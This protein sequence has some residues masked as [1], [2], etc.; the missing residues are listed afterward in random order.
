MRHARMRT[1][2]SIAAGLATS[3][4][5]AALAVGISPAQ[6]DPPPSPSTAAGYLAPYYTEGDLTGDGELT[7]DD[8]D[9]LVPAL[10]TTSAD[11]GWADVSAADYDDDSAITLTDVAD[12][13]RRLLYDDGPFD[14]VEASALDM[15]KAM[16]AGVVTSEQ[17]TQAYLDRITAYDALADETHARALNSVIATSAVALAAAQASDA[18]RAENGGPRSML[19]GI[20]ILLKDNYDTK[21]MPTTGGCGC[22]DENQTTDD[23]FMVKGLRDAGAIVLGKASLDEFAFGFVSEYSAGQPA[24]SSKLVASPYSLSRTAGG[25]SGGTGAA[26][27]AN[28]GGIGFGTDTGGSIRVPSSYNQLV[29]IR[30]TVGLASRD[31]I[32]PLALSQDTGGPMAR[33]VSDAAIALDAVTGVDSNDPRTAEQEGKVPTSYTSS[34]DPNALQG[35]KIGYLASMVGSNAT[36]TRLFQA[37]VADLQAQGAEVVPITID[38]IS[39]ILS[40]GSG[41]TNEFKHD[42]DAYIAAHLDADE[43]ERSLADIVA[44]GKY[45]PSRLNTYNTRNAVTAETYATWM[46]SHTQVL[47][48]G[49]TLVTAALDSNE[50]DAL[51]YPS[52]NPYSTQSTNLR[53]SPNTGLPAVTVPMGQAIEADATIPGAGVNLEFLGRAF[54]EADLIGMTYDYEQAT[55]H[56]TTPALYPALPGAAFRADASASVAAEASDG[57]SVTVSEPSV[58]IGDTIEVT[59]TANAAADLYA[60]DLDLGFDPEVLQYVG[61]SAGTG[62]SGATYEDAGDAEDGEVHVVHTKLGTSPAAAGEVELATLTFKAV[63]AGDTTVSADAVT[64]VKTDLS[65]TT[66]TELGSAGVAVGLLDAPV[67]SAL[68]VVHGVARPGQVL[69]ASPGTWNQ[70]GATFAYQWLA[71]G[72]PIPGA[73]TADYRVRLADSGSVLSVRVTA[74]VPDHAPGTATSGG[75]KV[76]PLSTVTSITGPRAVEK[77]KRPRVVVKVVTQSGVVPTGTV[78][79]WYGGHLIRNELRLSQGRAVLRLPAKVKPGRY[80][81]RAMFHPEK[82]FAP[83]SR[84]VWIRVTR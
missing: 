49:R 27:S 82:G 13:S 20:P 56:R 48:N 32:I 21:D 42:L 28:L 30:P 46:T 16:N 69:H 65:G 10:G 67:A 77:G 24:A 57:Y 70:P 35:R 18:A 25:S 50:L 40:E 53:L 80:R 66:E 17:L 15:Q 38:G 41:S 52:G 7:R 6:A 36:T 76:Q 83:S 64:S 9:V 60:Y 37:A 45:V 34:L 26:I 29:G 31:G 74:T 81:L 84:V 55:G 47:Q 58:K 78:D 11:T 71:G 22:W 3:L 1:T 2:T 79:V 23:A 75:V 73:T 62:V 12:L 54:D 72:S 8:L 5:V 19:D 61:G 33:S 14:L 68:P 63:G 4:A 44:S 39:P 59:V 43:T 51:I